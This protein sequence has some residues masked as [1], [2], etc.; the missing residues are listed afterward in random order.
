MKVL[1][2]IFLLLIF[3]FIKKGIT[4]NFTNIASKII[5]DNTLEFH[6]K[7]KQYC[8][9]NSGPD[10]LKIFEKAENQLKTK[11]QLTLETSFNEM[12]KMKFVHFKK[13]FHE[14]CNID[15]VV[16]N[17]FIATKPCLIE[18]TSYSEN[19]DHLNHI[20]EEEIFPISKIHQVIDSICNEMKNSLKEAIDSRCFAENFSKL[21]RC[22]LKNDYFKNYNWILTNFNTTNVN[23]RNFPYHVI[24]N[25]QPSFLNDLQKIIDFRRCLIDTLNICKYSSLGYNIELIFFPDIENINNLME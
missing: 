25:A 7:M 21:E 19:E 17:Y 14:F 13:Y 3:G 18:K 20:R 9:I 22:F 12:I 11:I 4:T 23:P 16:Y 15:F 24:T 1:N 2:T 10:A 5:N 6:E 8:L